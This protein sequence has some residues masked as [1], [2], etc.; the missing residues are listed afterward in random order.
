M[1]HV[2]TNRVRTSRRSLLKGITA[3]GARG[4]VRLPPPAPRSNPPG[5]AYTATPPPVAAAGHR[6]RQA[7]NP[8]VSAPPSTR[9]AQLSARHDLLATK[10]R[11]LGESRATPPAAS[12]PTAVPKAGPSATGQDN[13]GKPDESGR[14]NSGCHMRRDTCPCRFENPLL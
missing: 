2:I 4:P 13:N 9:R 11:E 3:P 8:L 7:M 12:D 14:P 6:P 1:S 10:V 5:T